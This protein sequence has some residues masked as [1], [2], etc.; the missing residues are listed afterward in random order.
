M[1]ITRMDHQVIF[2]DKP[3]PDKAAHKCGA[4]KCNNGFPRLS[5]AA[6]ES[7]GDS[8]KEGG[9]IRQLGFFT[10]YFGPDRIIF[11]TFA[12]TG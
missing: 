5:T 8:D 11:K 6:R 4:A 9:Q 2:I 12:R 7:G 10:A 1:T 3:R